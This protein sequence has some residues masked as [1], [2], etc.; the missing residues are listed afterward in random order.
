MIISNDLRISTL[1]LSNMYTFIEI[2]FVF[3]GLREDDHW[4][5]GKRGRG[6]RVWGTCLVSWR[7]S[8]HLIVMRLRLLEG[9]IETR[10]V[11]DIRVGP[12]CLFPPPFL[13]SSLLHFLPYPSVRKRRKRRDEEEK[14]EERDGQKRQEGLATTSP[15][16][17][18]RRPYP[19]ARTK[20]R[21]RDEEEWRNGGG[22]EGRGLASTL[23]PCSGGLNGENFKPGKEPPP[24]Y[25]IH[26]SKSVDTWY[27]V[28][29]ST[30]QQTFEWPRPV[31][32]A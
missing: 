20:G 32:Q 26:L 17:R 7:V 15:S 23:L 5:W 9:I 30:K 1:S 31:E 13:P 14:R 24:G 28:I 25:E 21:R 8:S 29:T 10:G 11:T 16:P 18:V 27:L 6:E 12:A 19:N 2:E 4:L 3:I 22:A